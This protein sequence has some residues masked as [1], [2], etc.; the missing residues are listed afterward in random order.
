M[1][2]DEPEPSLPSEAPVTDSD[3]RSFTR[4]PT[5]LEADIRLDDGRVVTGRASDVGLRGLFL[6]TDEPVAEGSTCVVTL[7]LGGR[8]LGLSL[9]AEGAVARRAEGGLGIA[10]SEVTHAAFHHLR[11]LIHFDA[12]GG[13]A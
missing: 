12:D 2:S 8:D 4:L 13:H 3:R 1:P 10:F 5:E 6:V 9:R 11:N 7:F